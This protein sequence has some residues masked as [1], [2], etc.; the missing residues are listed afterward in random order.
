MGLSVLTNVGSLN[1][2]RNLSQTQNSLETSLQR[3]STGLRINS[4]RD[5]AA[6]LAIST[7]I[8]AQ[9]RGLD[10]AARNSNDGIS[11]AQVAEG[12]L[13]ETT[14]VLQ[15]VRELAVQSANGTN[16][17]SERANLNTEVQQLIAE[18]DRIATQTEFNGNKILSS[19]G[20]FSASFQVGSDVAQTISLSISDSRA[21]AVGVASNFSTVQNE[22]GT[23]TFGNRL[24]L[25]FAENIDSTV[26]NVSVTAVAA[27]QNSI[28]KVNSL[29]AASGSTGVTAFSYGNSLNSQANAD[30]DA[31]STTLASGDITINGV[32]VRAVTNADADLE[33]AINEIAGQTG[34]SADN[35]AAD[36][37]SDLVLY[38]STGAAITIEVNT[39]NA[40]TRSG[41]TQGTNTV[42]AG[43]NG[44][45]VL[46][47]DVGS[48]TIT[49]GNAGT[50][51]A[52]TGTSG[53]SVAVADTVVSNLSVASVADANLAI[54]AVDQALTTINTTR[55]TL[56]AVQNRLTSTVSN[57]QTTSENLSAARSRIRDADF[58]AE[59]SALTKAQILQQA[60]VSVLSQA[61][62]SP[63]LALALL[64]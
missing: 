11:L 41:F 16:S 25:Q 28:G 58:A 6:G 50:G 26:N 45:I 17:A 42:A 21:N 18:V 39:A 30:D 54:L 55:A 3:L 57:L 15:R 35:G 61:N 37:T 38:N 52:L 32:D 64:S 12:A 44:A 4:A 20:G 7:N 62:A 1:A 48:N 27:D 46:N 36:S 63:Q 14:N 51:Q 10:Q 2:Q 34:V 53:T 9:I 24:R 60:G 8:T 31:G 23:T 13:N 5:D 56:G 29:N 22:F 59:T 40:A 33:A 47:Q 19:S 43:E 49:F